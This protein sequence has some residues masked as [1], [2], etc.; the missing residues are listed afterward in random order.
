MKFTEVFESFERGQAIR[1][2][3]W[4]ENEYIIRDTDSKIELV[5]DENRFSLDLNW[6]WMF[7]DDWELYLGE[8]T[9]L[10]YDLT[11]I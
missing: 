4:N 3:V 5:V 9:H 1:R 10:K 11:H 7:N 8:L 6:H 2:A